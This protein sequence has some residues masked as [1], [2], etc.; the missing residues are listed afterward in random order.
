MD[1]KAWEIPGDVGVVHRTAL[2][3]TG[4]ILSKVLET[5]DTFPVSPWS[6]VMTRL[7]GMWS[8]LAKDI[9][10]NLEK[11]QRKCT[12]DLGYN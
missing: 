10:E 1:G 3:G 2:L 7:T 11:A 4:K 9:T 6:F 12:T 8:I 5:G